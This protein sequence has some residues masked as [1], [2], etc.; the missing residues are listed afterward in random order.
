MTVRAFGPMFF[1]RPAPCV[2]SGAAIPRAFIGGRNWPTTGR[3]ASAKRSADF[4]LKPPCPEGAFYVIDGAD[5]RVHVNWDLADRL[6]CRDRGGVSHA[7]AAHVW[8]RNDR[9]SRC[10]RRWSRTAAFTASPAAA[11]RSA[12]ANARCRPTSARRCSPRRT[13]AESTPRSKPPAM[14]RGRTTRR[15]SRTSI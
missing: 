9:G 8:R 7:S 14:S 15:C 5:D 11:S 13:V 3:S 12:A 10:S 1:S 6:R 4:V 2:A